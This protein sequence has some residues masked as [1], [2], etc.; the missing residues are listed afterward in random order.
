MLSENEDYNELLLNHENMIKNISLCEKNCKFRE[1]INQL[2]ENFKKQKI[3][4]IVIGETCAGKTTFVN[5]ILSYNLTTNSFDHSFLYFLPTYSRENTAFLWIIEA[6]HDAYFHLQINNEIP[7]TYLKIESIRVEIDNLNKKQT[8][9][10][11]KMK[12]NNNEFTPTVIS[13]QIPKFDPNLRIIDAPG[14]SSEASKNILMPYI[15]SE[16]CCLIYLKDLC[17]HQNI[18]DISMKFIQSLQINE[19]KNMPNIFD[20]SIPF[21]EKRIFF[22]NIKR[23]ILMSLFQEIELK[24]NKNPNLILEMNIFIKRQ[25]IL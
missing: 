18:S 23:K 14:F 21:L 10:V 15:R 5:T 7:H 8:N 6:S 19:I 4:L 11:N 22:L 2:F 25:M 24:T 3:C 17:D 16:L 12:K 13:I 20:F 1:E 9:I